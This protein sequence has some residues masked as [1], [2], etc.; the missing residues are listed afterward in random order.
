MLNR[1]II[2]YL[3]EQHLYLPRY[4]HIIFMLFEH[5]AYTDCP[6]KADAVENKERSCQLIESPLRE[7]ITTDKI[8]LWQVVPSPMLTETYRD[9]I[10]MCYVAVTQRRNAYF[11]ML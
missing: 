1:R 4:L 9:L 6:E 7:Q 11:I 8:D 10:S 3:Y 5:G 2:S